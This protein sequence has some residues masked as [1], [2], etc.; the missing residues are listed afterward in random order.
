MYCIHCGQENP[1]SARFCMKCGKPILI[2]KPTPEKEPETPPAEEVVTTP[3]PAA[4]PKDET[5]LAVEEPTPLP[6]KPFERVKP[7]PKPEPRPDTP[8]EVEMKRQPLMRERCPVCGFAIR[9]GIR[10]CEGCGIQLNH[11]K[12]TICKTCGFINRPGTAFCEDCGNGLGVEPWE[13]EACSSC[14]Y[15]NRL[16]MRFCE[17]CGV[18]LQTQAE[19]VEKEKQQTVTQLRKVGFK[20]IKRYVLPRILGGTVGGF[21]VGKLGQWV[22]QNLL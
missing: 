9:P 17:G 14:G 19:T 10:Y 11:V 18:S 21:V 3:V 8:S 7:E 6:T 2:P 12:L 20:M 4:S 1:D 22:F 15:P 5:L 13:G 16:G